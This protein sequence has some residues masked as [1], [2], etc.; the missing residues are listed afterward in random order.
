MQ[1][2]YFSLTRLSL[3]FTLSIV[4]INCGG[5]PGESAG[6][7]ANT[8]A[9]VGFDSLTLSD[10]ALAGQGGDEISVV[11][12]KVQTPDDEPLAG[13]TV[14]FAISSDA[15]GTMLLVPSAVSDAEGLASTIVQSGN[16]AIA[17]TVEANIRDTIIRATS[18]QI[19]IGTSNLVANKFP[20]A[21]ENSDSIRWNPSFGAF[22]VDSAARITG[23]EVGLSFILADR[24]GQTVRD[25]I[26]V[27]IVSPETG[28]ISGKGC[29]TSDGNCTTTWR[30]TEGSAVG[31]VITILAY[32]SGAEAFT[33]QNGNNIY[34]PG[35]PFDDLGEAYADE[36]ENGVY[37]VGEF[38]FDANGN[39]VYDADGNFLWDGPC[40]QTDP[41]LCSGN[42]STIIWD[43]VRLRLL[44]E[45]EDE[46]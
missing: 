38:F 24:F 10:L 35:E 33:D 2:W 28:V 13:V 18:D 39:G 45:P 46:D 34:D 4:L 7:G 15:N 44:D 43:S 23:T 5:A 16:V 3:I 41:L 9:T 8:V 36:N 12:F 22:D 32:A 1:P 37:D 29:V 6:S 40:Q 19:L 30:S 27:T 26:G 31:R 21:V 25:N 17:V 14:D 42:S 20:I 11:T